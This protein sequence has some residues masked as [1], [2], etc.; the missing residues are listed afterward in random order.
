[1]EAGNGRQES[2]AG[3]GRT[4]IRIG[5][6]AA[7]ATGAWILMGATPAQAS[8]T[9][10]IS[11]TTLSITGDD[12][13][14]R[15]ALR[16]KAGDP[17]TLQVDVGDNGSANF[18][19]DRSLFDHIV[20]NAGAG[21]DV[22]RV[23]QINGGF[24]DTEL[25]TL[26][27]EPGA[28]TLT[29]GVGNET[30][31][32][33][34]GNDFVD[35][36]QGTDTALLGPGQDTFN[37]D[38]G[39]NSDVI[40][41][42]DGTDTLRFNGAN[43]AENIDL[44]ANGQ[45]LRFTRDIA[46]ITMDADGV[47]RVRFSALGGTDHVT[48][49]DLTGT[50][51]TNV[52][53]DL[54]STLGGTGGDGAADTVTVEGTAA[55]DQAGLVS[56]PGSMTVTGLVPTVTVLHPELAN[57][58]LQV[59]TLAGDDQISSTPLATL[60]MAVNVDGGDNTDTYVANGTSDADTFAVVAN[61]LATNVSADGATGVNVVTEHTTLAMLG[62]ADHV[63]A[64][65]NLAATTALVID[66]GDGPDGLFGGNGADAILGGD[67]A[68]F[69]DG[70]QGDDAVFLGAGNDTFNWDPGDGSDTVE[71]QAGIDTLR[72]NG[73]NIAEK[74]DLSAN[75]GRLR[76][77][78]DIANIVLD[79][80]DVERVHFGA[81]GGTDQV[82][83]DD[84]A[85]TDVTK[86]TVD[87][88]STL[89]GT[90]GDGA[91][92]TVI[93]NGTAGADAVGLVSAPGQMTVT[94][95]AP[96]VTVLH[97]ELANDLV[98][99]NTLAGNDQISSAP[100]ATLAMA[101]NVDGGTDDDTYTADGT[102]GADTFAVTA[103]GAATNVSGDGATGVNALTERTVLHMLG[104]EDHVSSVGNLAAITALTVDGGN[105]ADVLLGGNGADRLI[106]GAGG[107]F[108]DG[109]QGDDLALLGSGNDTFNWDPGDGSD[110]VE[111]QSD[112][113][114]LRFNGANIAENIDMSA[115]GQR[116]RFTR[117]IANIVL[118]VDGVEQV[119]FNALGGTDHVTVHDLAGTDVTGVTVDL[120]GTLGGV[121]GDGAADQVIVEGTDGAD[122]IA[123][124]GTSA[125]GVRVSGL[126]A[127][128]KVLHPEFANDRLD[129][130]T[131]GGAD[132]V[133]SGGLDPGVIQMFVDGVPR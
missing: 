76:F 13:S 75:G 80:D 47:E 110:T 71:G 51:V 68:D 74:I 86:V 21:D 84:L 111:G 1:M 28:D 12:A 63:T 64:V 4:L 113:D 60:P 82:T 9:A 53:T 98:Q 55:A 58:L 87:L 16:L 15:L 52:T 95:L 94:G 61:G 103:N 81:L 25:T 22:V 78:R 114:V 18:A 27:G 121:S 6:L 131:L 83:V 79:T 3:F 36:N 7:V 39:D 59:N 133:D 41:G 30:F 66:G 5:M 107:D 112:T 26:N 24:T 62:G 2:P 57:D 37:W 46:T 106:G 42:Q 89:G 56:A 69:I 97:P 122:S 128:V 70:N 8:Y 85:G 123:V 73:A 100:L 40:E 72:F 54:A 102:S 10:G 105:G 129:V 108:V 120:A 17:N 29:G 43:I 90:G 119:V 33:G 49:H 125:T 109:N 65:G 130:N 124:K 93:V 127:V 132:T 101:V 50:D 48:V 91:A 44:S 14:D 118:D 45:R 31:V 99:V 115:N 35:G 77:T 38:P 32:G 96:A 34:P 20:V 116:L 23:D 104:G 92:D 88:A 117:D 11:G 19:F 67:G 126:A